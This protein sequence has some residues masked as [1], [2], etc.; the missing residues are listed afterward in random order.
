[1]CTWENK[2]NQN[3]LLCYINAYLGGQRTSIILPEF[4]L[5]WENPKNKSY[6]QVTDYTN[7]FYYFK[8]STTR[9]TFMINNDLKKYIRKKL[10]SD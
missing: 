8:I 4:L 3:R 5:L 10:K 2:G 6:V 9:N 7:E 1:M